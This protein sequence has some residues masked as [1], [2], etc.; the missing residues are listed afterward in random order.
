M[1]INDYPLNLY[2]EDTVFTIDD[3][4]DPWRFLTDEEKREKEYFKRY[5]RLIYNI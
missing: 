4:D 3:S 1:F 5:L 2:D